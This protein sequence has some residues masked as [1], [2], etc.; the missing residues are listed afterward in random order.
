MKLFEPS[1]LI[2]L[3]VL[4]TMATCQSLNGNWSV[5]GSMPT[6]RSD[7]AIVTTDEAT[8]YIFGGCTG[9]Q[10]QP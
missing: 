6:S 8:A 4:L 5:V 3:L 7:M 2:L 1:K 10:V 9:Q